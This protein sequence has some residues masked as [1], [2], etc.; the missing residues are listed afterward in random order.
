MRKKIITD[1]IYKWKSKVFI[2]SN[3]HPSCQ[4]Y[5][6]YTVKDRYQSAEAESEAQEE[7][8]KW[9]GRPLE[10]MGLEIM[11]ES[12]KIHIRTAGGRQPQ[13]VGAAT[14]KLWAPSEVSTHAMESRLE[15]CILF[16]SYGVLKH[17]LHISHWLYTL[18]VVT[19]IF[20]VTN[21]RKCMEVMER[22][23][24]IW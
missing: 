19:V 14:L 2:Q 4:L 12:V 1:L 3:V 7:G 24:R 17:E 18:T 10:I 8:A 21:C 13:I 23:H 16:V 11:A 15:G 5:V 22:V 9:A 6:G 20:N